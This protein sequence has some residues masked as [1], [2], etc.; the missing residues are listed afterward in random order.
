MKQFYIFFSLSLFLL[1]PISVFSSDIPKLILDF[2]DFKL[3]NFRMCSNVEKLTSVD[4]RGLAD[5]KCSGSAQMSVECITE[6]KKQI[7]SEYIA[8]IDLRQESHGFINDKYSISWYSKD[9][10]ANIKKSLFEINTD[11]LI[12]LHAL[13][14]ADSQILI[15]DK[16]DRFITKISVKSVQTESYIAAKNNYIY[17]RLPVTDRR[18]PDDKT[19]DEFI[20]LVTC[21]PKNIW[22]HFHCKAGKGRTTTFMSMFDM[23]HNAD[24]VS[25]N[26]M[27]KR[28]YLF[29]GSNLTQTD[30]KNPK[31][32]N[33]CKKERFSFLKEF[34]LYCI[35]NKKS[36]FKTSW[37]D[38]KNCYEKSFR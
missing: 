7:K 3:R 14:G 13:L 37:S 32:I 9:N 6:L 29:G 16:K 15:A 31:E 33:L 20:K 38:W 26:D 19:V 4:T 34:Y 28:Q 30:T 25:F 17:I 11:E 24:K 8:N 12:K 21:L 2:S 27:L 10:W 35:E 18:K 5:L 22:Y 23:M 1:S 36:N